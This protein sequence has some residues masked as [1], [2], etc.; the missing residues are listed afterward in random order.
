MKEK[1]IVILNI[2]SYGMEGEGVAHEGAHTFFVPYAMAGER[3][4]VAVDHVKGNIAFAHIIKMIEPSPARRDPA[5]PLYGK[6][7]GCSLRH[8]PYEIQEEIK[9]ENVRT[10]FYKNAGIELGEIPYVESAEDG[11]RNKVAL[12]FGVENGKVVLGM[13]KRAT[14]RVL[15][16]SACP[17]HGEWIE[18]LIRET[19]DFVREHK[20]SVYDE[21]SGKGLLRHLVAR[22]LPLKGAYECSVIFVVNGAKI[23]RE[24]VLS[25][26]LA[27]SLDDKV[28]V[29]ICKNTMHN[30]VILTSDIRTLRGEDH[31]RA[32]MCGG[33][34]EVSPLSF[35]QVN[36]PVAESIYEKVVSEIPEGGFV[37]DAY[38]GTGIMSALIAKRARKVVGIE[39]IRDATLNAAKNAEAFGVGDKVT[40]LCGEVEKVL[41]D[42]VKEEK[43]Y[44]L[45]VDPPRA[46]LDP[47]II[48]TILACPPESIL[49]VSCSPATLT[50]DIG[51][52]EGKYALDEVKLF[53][54]FPGTP[55]VESVVLMSR[56]GSRQ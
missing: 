6:C 7:G 36:F 25:E 14:H 21:R 26:R 50:R 52:L 56:A 17:L 23:P 4:K 28:N 55:H 32:E 11:Y 37:V 24:E 18:P 13:Y 3:V 9:R 16:L 42:V 30:N 33:V 45:V 39:V 5:C 49:Y 15:P 34:W 48:D 1:D 27:A 38:S 54:I 47:T 31:I 20:I 43:D 51:R 35:L 41:P 44:T 2:E 40:H 29:Y 53:D 12:P 19:L 8:I 22:R 10:L 46:G